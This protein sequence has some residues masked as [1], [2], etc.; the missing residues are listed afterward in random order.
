MYRHQE[1]GPQDGETDP[2]QAQPEVLGMPDP[3]VQTPEGDP[4]PGELVI[5]HLAR[6]EEEHGAPGHE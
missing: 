3:G 6:A 1:P 5:V 4:L 2:R